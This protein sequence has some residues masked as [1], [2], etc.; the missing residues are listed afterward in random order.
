MSNSRLIKQNTDVEP[1]VSVLTASASV[2]RKEFRQSSDEQR[3][4]TLTNRQ[5]QIVMLVALGNSNREIARQL[6]LTEGTVKVHLHNIHKKV[7]VP[8]RTA[9]AA[10]VVAQRRKARPDP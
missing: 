2:P 8:N 5:R 6:D 4:K 1:S 3:L 7:G 10:L 9:L